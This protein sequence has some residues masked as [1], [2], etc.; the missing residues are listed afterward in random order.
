VPGDNRGCG[1]VQRLLGRTA[2]AINGGTGDDLRP[3]GAED[4]GACD[5]EGLFPD[6]A[7]TAP[8]DVVDERG[9]DAGAV[10]QYIAVRSGA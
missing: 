5:V 8:H 10:D 4:G 6:L 7:H 9:V 3:A 2:L 1:E